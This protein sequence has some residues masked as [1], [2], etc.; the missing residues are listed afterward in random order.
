MKI[1]KNEFDVVLHQLQHCI[2]C[3][4]KKLELCF[5]FQIF[6]NCTWRCGG[7]TQDTISDIFKL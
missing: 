1:C 7:L 5:W 3:S 4:F 6:K 2:K